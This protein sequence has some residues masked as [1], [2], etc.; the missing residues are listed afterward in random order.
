MLSKALAVVIMIMALALVWQKFQIDG[1]KLEVEVIGKERDAAV[2]SQESLRAEIEFNEGQIAGFVERI[3][4][5]ES[6]RLEAE[7]Q[8]AYMRGLFQ[9]HDFAR[10]ITAKPG[11]IEKRM[12]AKTEEVMSELEAVTQ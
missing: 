10:L 2:N 5:I 8:V 7:R 4:V 12:I 3:A 11:L 9:D 6:E 1:L